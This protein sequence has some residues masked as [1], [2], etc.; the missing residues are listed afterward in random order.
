MNEN[1][2]SRNRGPYNHNTLSMDNLTK[3]EAQLMLANHRDAIRGQSRSANL[4]PFHMLVISEGW[5]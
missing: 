1:F 3:Q 2:I 4:V 5:R